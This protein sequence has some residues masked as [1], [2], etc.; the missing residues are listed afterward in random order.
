MHCHKTENRAVF[1]RYV[2]VTG[3]IAYDDLNEYDASL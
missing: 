3:N 2:V 1:L